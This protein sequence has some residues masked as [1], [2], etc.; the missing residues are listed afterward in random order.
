MNIEGSCDPRFER[1][2]DAFERNF[3]ERGDVGASFAA[4]LEGECV[5]DIWGGH[6]DAERTRPWAEDTI[7]NVFSTTKTMTFIAALMLADRGQL[8]LDAP[9]ADYWPEFAANGKA[10]VL[11]KHLLAHSAAVPGFSRHFSAEEHYDWSLACADLAG[12]APWWPP[13]SRSGYHAI[14]QGYLIGEVVRR[15]TGASFGAF[16]KAEVA[17]VVGAD[18]HIGTGT[19]HFDRI[20]EMIPFAE[21]A[22]L[23]EADPD[24]IPGR[25]FSNI[26]VIDAVNTPGW[27][28]A[29]IPAANGHGNARS[30]VRAQTAMANGGRAF[31]KELLS[32]EGCR[33]AFVEQTDGI[34]AVLG[35]HVRYGMGYS[36]GSDA[37]TMSPNPGILWWC[38]AG[39]STI[40]IDADA[41][42]CFS[43]VMNRM[44]NHI[45]GDPRGLSLGKAL[46]ECL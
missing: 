16:F 5:V 17:D 45:L 3:T 14:T 39:G 6:Q 38:G 1:V 23:L 11:V 12:Q 36:T 42:L 7:V 37:I 21:P 41:R 10:G 8:N 9:V 35:F 28:Q 13:G 26:D 22:P 44:D 15:I 43:Y 27:R 4:T 18:F 32:A 20:A 24:T 46:Y 34:D 2:R 25:V 33:T 30:V 40:V 19:G 29:E 31:G